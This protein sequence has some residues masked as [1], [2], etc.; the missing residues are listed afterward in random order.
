MTILMLY[1]HS[2]KPILLS[3][4]LPL[5]SLRVCRSK[6]VIAEPQHTYFVVLQYTILV[7]SEVFVLCMAYQFSVLYLA[8]VVCAPSI[9]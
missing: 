4:Q 1:S 7:R 3:N 2:G 8:T 9:Q 5:F 6:D